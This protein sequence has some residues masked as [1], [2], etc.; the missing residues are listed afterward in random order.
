[1]SKRNTRRTRPGTAAR[2]LAAGVAA[3]LLAACGREPAA[4][5]APAAATAAASGSDLAPVYFDWFEYTGR[6]AAFEA[7]LPDGSFR[8]PVLSGFHSDP[9]VTAANGKFYLVASTF[10]SSP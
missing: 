6:D 8:N 7:P 4:P 2:I 9:S 5:A 10:A 3:L 1:M